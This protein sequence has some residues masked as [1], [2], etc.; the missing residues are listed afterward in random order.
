MCVCVRIIYFLGYFLSRSRVFQKTTIRAESLE[1]REIESIPFE[2]MS[3]NVIC[4]YIVYKTHIF[5]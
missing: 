2:W 3:I 5:A 4:E 1:R